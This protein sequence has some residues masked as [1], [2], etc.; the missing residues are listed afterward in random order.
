M[1]KLGDLY[2]EILFKDGTG[3]GI[4]SIEDKIKRLNSN[5][6]LGVDGKKIVSDIQGALSKPFE[7]KVNAKVSGLES[8]RSQMEQIASSAASAITAAGAAAGKQARAGSAQRTRKKDSFRSDY[9][10]RQEFVLGSRST[11]RN[12]DK[13]RQAAR[14]FRSIYS[15]TANPGRMMTDM[16]SL[17]RAAGNGI[18]TLSRYGRMVEEVTRQV[19]SSARKSSSAL[20]KG[21][22]DF[23]RKAEERAMMYSESYL[24]RIPAD[25]WMRRTTRALSQKSTMT[26]TNIPQKGTEEWKAYQLEQQIKRAN[27]RSDVRE[28]VAAQQAEKALAQRRLAARGEKESL[29]ARAEMN[30]S[31]M[32]EQSALTND[33]YER[34]QLVA[35]QKQKFN[36]LRQEAKA[37]EVISRLAQRAEEARGR[38]AMNNRS[39]EE[40]ARES[41]RR[42]LVSEQAQKLRNLQKNESEITRMMQ[43]A[44]EARGRIH[45]HNEKTNEKYEH[46]KLIE[47]QKAQYRN[48]QIEAKAQR[49]RERAEERARREKQK[50]EAKAQRERERAEKKALLEKQ[51]QEARAQREELKR[52]ANLKRTWKRTVEENRRERRAYDKSMFNRSEAGSRF[53]GMAE[54]ALARQR[55]HNA[56]VNERY[57][58]ARLIEQQKVRMAQLKREYA[59]QKRR[60]AEQKKLDAEQKKRDAASRKVD[61]FGKDLRRS[62]T[63]PSS[64]REGR[65]VSDIDGAIKR[66]KRELNSNF[67]KTA[68]GNLFR[69]ISNGNVHTTRPLTEEDRKKY[70]SIQNGIAALNFTRSQMGKIGRETLT[71]TDV[72][73]KGS[74]AY[75]VEKERRALRVAESRSAYKAYFAEQDRLARENAQKEKERKAIE[76]DE[77][78]KAEAKAKAD[79]K[80]IDALMKQSRIAGIA[81]TRGEDVASAYRNMKSSPY[82]AYSQGMARI[83]QQAESAAGDLMNGKTPTLTSARIA[84]MSREMSGWLQQYNAISGARKSVAGQIGEARRVMANNPGR[85]DGIKEQINRMSEMRSKMSEAASV[86]QKAMSG[87]IGSISAIRDGKYSAE[88]LSRIQ[89]NAKAAGDAV[90]NMT[91]GI[92]ATNY[93]TNLRQVADELANVGDRGSRVAE[94]LGGIFSVYAAK[95]FFNNLVQIGGEFEKQKLALASMFNSQ[96]RANTLYSQIQSLAVKSPFTFGELTSYTKQL[97]A[98]GIQYNDIYD[99]TKRLADISAA[100][101]VPMSRII[102][103]YGQVSTAK[104]LRGQEL[105]QFTEAGIPLVDALA[106]RFTKLK[107]EMVSADDVFNMISER[108]VKFEDVKAVLDE[109]TDKG[110]RFYDMQNVLSE[111]LSGKWSNLQ[112]SI[113]IMYSEIENSNKGFLKG[114]VEG[115]TSIVRNWQ[116]LIDGGSALLVLYGALLA[117][118]KIDYLLNVKVSA[119]NA[120]TLADSY[121]RT[122]AL[123]RE[124]EA[125]NRQT[126]AIGVNATERQKAAVRR[127]G[128]SMILNGGDPSKIVRASNGIIQSNGYTKRLSEVSNRLKEAAKNT[129]TFR[130]RVQYL[131]AQMAV[132]GERGKLALSTLGA[133]IKSLFTPFNIVMG[134]VM[135]G[136]AIFSHYKEKEESLNEH[137]R[138]SMKGMKQNY[139]E[140]DKFVKDHPIEVAIA[141]GNETTISE[142]LKEYKEE[143]ENSPIDI[144]YVITHAEILDTVAERL[145]Y[146]RDELIGLK[147][148]SQQLETG[149]SSTSRAIDS[150][151]GGWFSDSLSKNISDY[152]E[153]KRKRD[154]EYAKMRIDDVNNLYEKIAAGTY[155][156]VKE[157]DKELLAEWKRTLSEMKK[158][159]NQGDFREFFNLY[160][161]FRDQNYSRLNFGL[162][163]SRTLINASE[164]YESDVRK[165]YDDMIDD[166]ERAMPIIEG[167]LRKGHERIVKEN[168]EIV[169]GE[170]FTLG[171]LTDQ[172]HQYLLGL[173]QDYITQGK[174]SKE[175]VDELMLYLESKA[176]PAEGATWQET[177]RTFEAFIDK[178]RT[179]Y[180]GAFKGKEFTGTWSD[181]QKRSIEEAISHIDPDLQPYIGKLKDYLKRYEKQLSLN[182]A[183]RMDMTGIG[184]A[185]L[186]QTEAYGIWDKLKTKVGSQMAYAPQNGENTL[187]WIDRLAKGGKSAAEEYYSYTKISKSAMN[188]SAQDTMKRK[189]QEADN[190]ANLLDYL[191]PAKAEEIRH[192]AGGGKEKDKADKK[193]KAEE[194]AA[195]KAERER[196]KKLRERI[197]RLNDFKQMYAK[198][199]Q[200]YGEVE[201]MQRLLNSGLFVAGFAPK[202]MQSEDDVNRWVAMEMGK[203]HKSAGNKTDEQR[204]VGESA[205]KTKIDLQVEIDKKKL[206]KELKD[207]ERKLKKSKKDWERYMSFREAGLSQEQSVMLSFGDG[208]KPVTEEQQRMVDVQTFLSDKGVTGVDIEKLLK[209]DKDQLSDYFED[210]AMA[211]ALNSLV[212]AYREA[213]EKVVD[214]ND[215]MYKEL[216][217]N[218][219]GYDQKIADAEAKHSKQKSAI[220][221]GVKEYRKTGG[222]A[223]LSPEVAQRLYASNDQERDKSIGEAQMEQLRNT[224]NYLNFFNAITT[225]TVE[226]ATRIG[227]AIEQQL[228]MKLMAGTIS[229]KDYADEIDKI[230]QQMEKVR[231]QKTESQAT[232]NG[233]LKGRIDRQKNNAKDRW[234]AANNAFQVHKT[235]YNEAQKKGNTEQMH[236]AQVKMEADKVEMD[237]AVAD[238]DK[239][240][241]REERMNKDS[242]AI[243][244][245][246]STSES[247]TQFRDSLWNTIES[248]GGETD[249]AGFQ[250]FST[251]VD[252][253]GALASGAQDTMQ[254]L[255]TGDFVGAAFS[256]ITAPLN[257]ITAFN[258]LHDSKLQKQIELSEERSKEI[259]AAADQIQHAIENSLGSDAAKEN[260]MEAYKQLSD[261]MMAANKATLS[262]SYKMVY[263]SLSDP[264][265]I[266]AYMQKLYRESNG[267][268][269]TKGTGYRNREEYEA[270]KKEGFDT[271]ESVSA[272]GAQYIALLEQRK[273]L[274]SRLKNEKGKKASSKEKIAG[275]RDE[276]SDLNNQINEL[277]ETMLKDILGLDFKSWADSLASNLVNAFKSGQNAA[278]AFEKSVNDML[279][280]ITQNAIKQAVIMPFLDKLKGQIED[281]YDI[282]SPDS[283]DKVVD[284]IYK[285]EDEAMQVIGDAQ[286]IWSKVNAKANGALDD[287]SAGSN[288]ISGSA[289]SLTEETGSLIASY[290]NALR[291]DVAIN[292][293]CFKKLMEESMPKVDLIME[294]QLKELSTIAR[295]SALIA[296]NTEASANA[297]KSIRDTIGSVVTVGN[298]GKAVRIK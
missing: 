197:N 224:E 74:A 233:G 39:V 223:G 21:Y 240:A 167:S 38:I 13:W 30:R 114:I 79:Q 54:S 141:S 163:D 84:E 225:M 78:K 115:M 12:D 134:L 50:Q 64:K 53:I 48:L 111:S 176:T 44:E 155:I 196:L 234:N 33:R 266:K 59:E 207:I 139:M 56:S 131:N 175:E 198:F 26:V 291:A 248:F 157:S 142:L 186:I 190:Y 46:S 265:R 256:A 22:M 159:M 5:I 273:E 200:A 66:Y 247:L 238:Y 258:K 121:E 125:F 90:R 179:D 69:K 192:A 3:K 229:A 4:K 65:V 272:Y 14:E 103:A 206:D 144:G 49:E 158:A 122:A 130:G 244:K 271:T 126:A 282:N 187:D 194:N 209:M 133:G 43:R 117:K 259:K 170:A 274:E 226:E 285:S 177:S 153:A 288:T 253:V 185:P 106:K 228:T 124:T 180:V 182:I 230:R 100:V 296:E 75:N 241:T 143:I 219:K 297:A 237:D 154:A 268:T 171:K 239:A 101:G 235:E 18:E 81:S 172:G 15:R 123:E 275:Y 169:N 236:A 136:I 215:Q 269:D 166:M 218:A 91:S 243:G 160:T 67:G 128:Y 267:A 250:T 27:K 16:A 32:R 63:R 181:V 10:M 119:V 60:D 150:E 24:N 227:K 87:D 245:F 107:G 295:N 183:V 9:P 251:V 261:Q 213:W 42:S 212:E 62:Y 19:T 11:E 99:T 290:L 178:L 279:Q 287:T 191:N 108:A 286:Q 148:V 278:E 263:R 255:M 31:R 231:S 109:M 45:A 232:W 188:R 195:E 201:G 203:I 116:Y 162:D 146:I 249:S 280:T 204:S 138:E 120:K 276:L 2:Y 71:V 140:L 281:V 7:I 189:K 164:R 127:M 147:E 55:A 93:A 80:E 104:F 1:S 58:R 110:G 222:K 214:D 149:A 292:K 252:S 118:R 28:A 36:E 83:K 152:N 102:L 211:D 161:N 294:A 210:P 246:A 77:K 57:E 61:Q 156:S 284:L 129:D 168:G 132:M 283:I 8:I 264:S 85:I 165:S 20:P 23:A 145:K 277:K 72:P 220:D 88:W 89:Q 217:E 51:R 205:L 73:T 92:Q 97:A 6:V 202:G 289:K 221:A 37:R 242:N 193:A 113:E 216:L 184:G 68:E 40:R 52:L 112:D 25:G 41:E 174:K 94:I 199:V 270:L 47:Q 96:T 208:S 34:S 95:E 98:Y 173:M 262:D 257:V 254:K 17:Q 105:R 35:Q 86:Y 260:A 82:Y 70:E 135:G 293:M 29:V 298:G 137:A 76:R 151:T